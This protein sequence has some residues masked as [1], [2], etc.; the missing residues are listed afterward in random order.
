MNR[1]GLKQQIIRTA[2][3]A[4]VGAA[5]LAGAGVDGGY[6]SLRMSSDSMEPLTRADI[7]YIQADAPAAASADGV[8]SADEWASVYP[9][10]AL[11]MGENAKKRISRQLSGRISLSGQH[12]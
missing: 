10:I 2:A 1:E 8:I 12:L 11:S 7:E 3:A 9:E 6:Y 5:L 4:A